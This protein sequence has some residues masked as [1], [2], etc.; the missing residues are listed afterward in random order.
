MKHIKTFE[1]FVYESSYIVFIPF[2]KGSDDIDIDNQ[3]FGV[4]SEEELNRIKPGKQLGHTDYTTSGSYKNST[5]AEKAVEIIKKGKST[6]SKEW[7]EYSKWDDE[8]TK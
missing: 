4:Y 6:K 5:D 1:N 7:K 3:L 8:K 2:I